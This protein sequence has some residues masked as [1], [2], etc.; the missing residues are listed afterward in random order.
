MNRVH[1]KFGIGTKYYGNIAVVCFRKIG[2]IYNVVLK[3]KLSIHANAH[4]NQRFIAIDSKEG[5]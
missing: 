4:R 5:Q 3:A 1:L 2:H